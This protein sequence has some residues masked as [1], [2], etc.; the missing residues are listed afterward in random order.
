MFASPV[1]GTMNLIALS[2]GLFLEPKR[3]WR[4][5]RR[6]CASGNLY[7][8]SVRQQIDAGR[9]SQVAVLRRDFVEVKSFDLPVAV[10][11]FEFGCYGAA[12]MTIHAF[13]AIPA[14]FVRVITDITLGYT[15]FQAVKPRKR[16]DLY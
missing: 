8:A 16:V 10:R 5:F 11:T 9:W 4:A 14:V 3:M 12:A 13:I 15:F 1:L 2:T 7:A 6:G